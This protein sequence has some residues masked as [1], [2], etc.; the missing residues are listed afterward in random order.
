MQLYVLKRQRRRLRMQNGYGGK[1]IHH[2]RHIYADM[3][4]QGII[5][6]VC[7]SVSVLCY[8]FCAHA[9]AQFLFIQSCYRHAQISCMSLSV[10]SERKQC[11][12]TIFRIPEYTIYEEIKAIKYGMYALRR[13][14]IN[15]QL[16]IGFF[17]TSN[18]MLP[19]ECIF[20]SKHL[21]VLYINLRHN[22]ILI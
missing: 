16:A 1:G 8:K 2:A 3:C 7:A 21:S 19:T 6:I 20:C 4:C 10:F 9:S 13:V 15:S 5:M 18:N 12:M 17:F 22:Q 11:S 14:Y